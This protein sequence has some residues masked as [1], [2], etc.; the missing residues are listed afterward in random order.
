MLFRSEAL[1]KEIQRAVEQMQAGGT[2]AAGAAR[3]LIAL[4]PTYALSYLFLGTLLTKEGDLEEAESLLWQGVA[5]QPG[6][7]GF[8]L[9]LADVLERRD[10]D[11][12]LSKPLR[13]LALWNISFLQELPEGVASLFADH[14]GAASKMDFSDPKTFE[15]LATLTEINDKGA[16]DLPEVRER[17][18]PY[19]LLTDL[20]RQAP[21]VVDARLLRDILENSARCEPVWRAA[22]REWAAK[23]KSMDV[24]SIQLIVVQLG[25]IS[26]PGVIQDLLEPELSV[27]PFFMHTHWAI[28]RLGRRYPLETLQALRQAIP[29]AADDVRCGIGEQLGMLPAS[30]ENT[31]A[32]VELLQGF[33]GFAGSEDAPSLLLLVAHLLKDRGEKAQA[34]ALVRRHRATLPKRSRALMDDLISGEFGPILLEQGIDQHDIEDVCLKRSLMD[35]EDEDIEEDEDG[36]DY[37]DEFDDL[38]LEQIEPVQAPIRPGRNDPCWCGS[39][40]KYKKCHLESDES[41]NRAPAPATSAAASTQPLASSS[42]RLLVRRLIP[43]VIGILRK[44]TVRD[45]TR[46]LHLYFDKSPEEV[47]ESDLESGDFMQWMVYDF[48]APSTGRTGIEEYLHRRRFQL[49]EAERTALESL[50]SARYGL[51]E[52]QS[53]EEG[54]GVHLR[55]LFTEDKFFVHDISSSKELVQWDCVLTRVETLEERHEFSGNGIRVPRTQVPQLLDRIKS[56]ARAAGEPPAEFVR[57]NSHR[58][59]RVAK[60]IGEDWLAGLQVRNAEGDIFEFCS[61]TYEIRD[62]PALL[63]ALRAVEEYDE[64]TSP[65][66]APG[67]FDFVWLETGGPGP[68]RSFGQILIQNTR[69]K[70]E[71]NSRNRLELGRDILEAKASQFLQHVGDSFQSLEAVKKRVAKEPPAK[72]PERLPPDVEREVILKYYKEHY[73]KWV[74]QSLPALQGKTPR[75]AVKTV[76]GRQAVDDLIRMME[77]GAERDRKEGHPAF[78]FQ[79]LRKAL[80][81]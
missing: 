39:G 46:A 65:D 57:A 80:G 13:Q 42:S 43:E 58:L 69:L 51:Y 32:L 1:Q 45:F 9:Q 8:Y 11:N 3:R 75:E 23:P 71:C 63:E 38:E 72:Q 36:E 19:K 5:Q 37:Q 26:S 47:E 52:V 70:L 67:A 60:E 44:Q 35:E 55:D 40:K 77:N 48:R 10:P 15:L 78:D 34:E 56:E 68:R 22:L 41:G 49:S 33:D 21:T 29:S 4:D 14:A 7:F 2:G 50:R 25:E 73:A 24:A 17:L 53:V 61:A 31:A 27:Y 76:A 54:R 16:F 59:H 6:Q 74:D 18:L 66:S 30:P 20:K 62:Q 12:A 64:T 28:W 81:L 79:P